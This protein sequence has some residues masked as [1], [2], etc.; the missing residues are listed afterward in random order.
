MR[1]A[2]LTEIPQLADRA[3]KLDVVKSLYCLLIVLWRDERF[4][5]ISGGRRCYKLKYVPKFRGEGIKSAPFIYI[6][7]ITP[8]WWKAL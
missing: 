8:D 6:L 7:E 5:K 1:V 2:F 4:D 3:V